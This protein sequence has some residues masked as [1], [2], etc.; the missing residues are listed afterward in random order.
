ML[1]LLH[2]ASQN[3]SPVSSLKKKARSKPVTSHDTTQLVLKRVTGVAYLHRLPK[4]LKL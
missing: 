2:K 1:L 3:F 4:H